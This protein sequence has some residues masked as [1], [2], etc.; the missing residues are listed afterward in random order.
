MEIKFCN[1]QI[2]VCGLPRK[3]IFEFLSAVLVVKSRRSV[4]VLKNIIDH[5]SIPEMCVVIYFRT[6]V[7]EEEI[8]FPGRRYSVNR[9]PMRRARGRVRNW[10]RAR[11]Q[12]KRYNVE[13]LRIESCSALFV[14]RKSSVEAQFSEPV[15]REARLNKN[16][17]LRT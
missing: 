7:V 2:V 13:L 17:E 1:F 4:A 8:W 6:R 16:E 9:N 15:V 12:V 11:A 10:K 5:L 3:K 14:S